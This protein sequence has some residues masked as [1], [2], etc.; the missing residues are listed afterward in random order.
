MR[1]RTPSMSV[2]ASSDA[3]LRAVSKP[4]PMLAPVIRIVLLEYEMVGFAGIFLFLEAL[5]RVPSEVLGKEEGLFGIV[6]ELEESWE[7]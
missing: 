1:E 2:E 4:S 6:F 5:H 7:V 3:N